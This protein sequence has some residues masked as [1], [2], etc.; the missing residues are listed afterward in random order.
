MA[1]L[2]TEPGGHDLT[3]SAYVF[4]AANDE[5]RLWVHRHK[6]LDKWMQFGGHVEHTEQPWAAIAHE[7]TEESGYSLRQLKVLQPTPFLQPLTGAVLH[8]ANVCI[9][10]HAFPEIDHYH[11]DI[12]YA[13]VTEQ[14]PDNPPQDGESSDLK[15]ITRSELLSLEAD[16]IPESSREIALFIFDHILSSWQP[17]PATDFFITS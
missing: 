6:K 7:L 14:L 17:I 1:H 8:P 15:A 10:T 9:N 3:V 5:T 11:T 4:I 13:F 16:Q 12:S 2:H